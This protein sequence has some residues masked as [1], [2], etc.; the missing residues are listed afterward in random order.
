MA[1]QQMFVLLQTVHINVGDYK[2]KNFAQANEKLVAATLVICTTT[3]K[4]ASAKIQICRN[5]NL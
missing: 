1:H 2:K 5:A 4:D 3:A